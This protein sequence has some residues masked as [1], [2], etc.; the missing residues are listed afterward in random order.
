MKLLIA[1]YS[2]DG[3]AFVAGQ[4]K[5]LEKGN[6]RVAAEMIEKLTGG[7]L[8]RIETVKSYPYDYKETVKVAVEEYKEKARPELKGDLPSLSSYSD[9][10][11]AYPNWC[12]TMPMPV[13]TFIEALKWDGKNVYPLCTN[14]GSGLAK[15]EDEIKKECVGATV[16]KGLSLRGCKV[17]ESE[18][19]IKEWLEKNNLL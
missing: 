6:T 17:A 14:E 12:G 13:Y 9:I 4:I 8:F 19:K 10:I 1:Y 16:A 2:H 5:A 15:S 11:I 7:T 18:D 3:E